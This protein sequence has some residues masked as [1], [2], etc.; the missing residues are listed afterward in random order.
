MVSFSG[1][2]VDRQVLSINHGSGYVSSFEP[3]ESELE[4][5]DPVSA[6]QAVASLG[7]YEHGSTHCTDRPCLHWGVRR[8]SEYINPRLLL[9]DLEPSVLLPLNEQ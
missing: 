5:G 3:V 4:V 8:H 7:S 2:V 1:A 9:G 6:G